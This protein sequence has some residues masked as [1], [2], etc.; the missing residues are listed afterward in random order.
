MIS[1]IGV[2]SRFDKVRTAKISKKI[3]EYLFFVIIIR[4]IHKIGTFLLNNFCLQKFQDCEH[5]NF[6]LS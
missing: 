6:F 5:F 4:K 3:G 1:L 2:F